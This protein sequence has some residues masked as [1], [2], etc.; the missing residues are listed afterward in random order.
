MGSPFSAA[1]TVLE[2]ATLLLTVSD[3]SSSRDDSLTTIGAG[4]LVYQGTKRFRRITAVQHLQ[5]ERRKIT[6]II[7]VFLI[8]FFYYCNG[9]L[10]LFL[11][12]IPTWHKAPQADSQHIGAHTRTYLRPA[13]ADHCRCC[14]CCWNRH[15][16][17][18]G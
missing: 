18:W 16:A 3:A 7:T 15:N 8:V 17:P 1:I 13:A 10:F 9:N 4:E 14:C 5:Q 2:C 12:I 11:K 6:F